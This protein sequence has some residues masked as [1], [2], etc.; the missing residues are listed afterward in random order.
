MSGNSSGI[1]RDPF[2]RFSGH[3]RGNLITQ[4]TATFVSDKGFKGR[5]VKSCLSDVALKG[6]SGAK[7]MFFPVM[8]SCLEPLNS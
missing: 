3:L 7:Y 2:H 4:S 8:E 5:A 6:V 1:I